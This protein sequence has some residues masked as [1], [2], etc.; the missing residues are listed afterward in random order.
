M[1]ARSSI[2][3]IMQQGHT[4][5]VCVHAG[6]PSLNM[7]ASQ[8]LTS[9]GGEPFVAFAKA[10][11]PLREVSLF[12]GILEPYFSAGAHPSAVPHSARSRLPAFRPSHSLCV[13]TWMC[14]EER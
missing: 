13:H 7:S 10:T 8:A 1:G 12:E 5:R 11:T 2:P 3:R 14:R 6:L 4:P 9:A